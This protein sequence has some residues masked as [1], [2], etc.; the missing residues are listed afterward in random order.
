MSTVCVAPQQ[1]ETP[2]YPCGCI[3]KIRVLSAWGDPFYVG[4]NGLELY[5]HCYARLELNAEK[6]QSL[7]NHYDCVAYGKARFSKVTPPKA[8]A[9]ASHSSTTVEDA[10]A[11]ESKDEHPHMHNGRRHWPR[12]PP[13]PAPAPAPDSLE[14]RLAAVEKKLDRVVTLLER[15]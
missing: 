11:D 15:G 13:P 12:A 3:F 1:Y 6:I 5:D 8:Q 4:L 9:E 2:L 7:L 14:M 10:P